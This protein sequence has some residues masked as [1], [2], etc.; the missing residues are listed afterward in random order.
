MHNITHQPRTLINDF[1]V[2]AAA[3]D[4]ASLSHQSLLT[5][6]LP[7]EA[8]SVADSS[9][10]APTHFL[11]FYLDLAAKAALLVDTQGGQVG[12]FHA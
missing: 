2:Q 11:D 4:K 3:A 12:G 10:T 7:G 8:L 6:C 5:K 1:K 9:A